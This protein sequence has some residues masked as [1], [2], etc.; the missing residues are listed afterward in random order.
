MELAK[1]I[2]ELGSKLLDGL[3]DDEYEVEVSDFRIE[4][5]ENIDD[6]GNDIPAL[7]I[8]FGDIE[9]ENYSVSQEA[10]G[11]YSGYGC[12]K[13]QSWHINNSQFQSLEDAE[14]KLTYIRDELQKAAS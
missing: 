14:P 3:G 6:D 13:G 1:E 8:W 2:F 12:P 7:N 4:Y 10:N 9:D 5:G 11:E